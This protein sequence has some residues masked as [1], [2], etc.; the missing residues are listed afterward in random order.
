MRQSQNVKKISEQSVVLFRFAFGHLGQLFVKAEGL[1]WLRRGRGPGQLWPIW[2]PW[3]EFLGEPIYRSVRSGLNFGLV[4][5]N[6]TSN[7]KSPN[8]WGH[9]GLVRHVAIGPSDDS[10][11]YFAGPDCKQS[12]FAHLYPKSRRGTGS[13]TGTSEEKFGYSSAWIINKI[14]A[15]NNDSCCF[16]RAIIV[17]ELEWLPKSNAFTVHEVSFDK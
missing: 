1:T 10:V 3:L 15:E 8:I 16:C 11:R 7:S 5:L 4:R 13:T 14:R 6:L 9:V 2:D 17:P 12:V